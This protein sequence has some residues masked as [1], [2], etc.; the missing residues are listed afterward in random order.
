MNTTKSYIN[1]ITGKGPFFADQE[2]PN[3]NILFISVDMVPREFYENLHGFID[4]KTPNLSA[5]KRDHIFFNNA[6]CSSPLCTP[7]RASYLSGRYSY[8]TVNGERA[9]DGHAV[10]VREEDILFPEYLKSTGYHLRHVGKSHVGAHKFIEMFSENDS[11]WDRWSPPWFDDD[12]YI[13]YLKNMGLERITFDKT[14]YGQD[15]SGQKKGNFYGGWIAPQ[16]GKP[17][18]KEATYPAYLVKKTIQAFE[19]RQNPE[20]PFYFQLDFFGPHQ[21]F[22]IPAGMEEREREIR[23]VLELPESYQHLLNNNFQAF[24]EEP[25]VYR[26]YRKNWGL[27]DPEAMKEYMIA[28]LLQFE[29]LDE[30]IGNVLC[31]LQERDLYDNTWIFLIADH[32]EMNGEMAL[33]D[34]GAYLNPGVIRVPLYLKPSS[35]SEFGD[36]GHIVE[37]P[38]SLLDIAPTIFDITGI[39]TEERLDGISLF[40]TLQNT[41]RPDNKPILCEIW[42]HVIPNPAIGMVFTASDRKKYMFTFNASDDLDEL[43]ELHH[44]KTLKNLIKEENRAVIFEEAIRRMDDIL[45]QDKRWFGYSNFFKLTYAEKLQQPFGDRQLFF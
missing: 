21:P 45:E 30:M 20:Q 6:F 15:P 4:V 11:P 35:S 42:S 27:T 9:H 41:Q 25:R 44:Q 31:Y 23:A 13:T 12:G 22:A 34:K 37:E 8:I 39:S 14:I 29:L 16:N 33:I 5:L 43:Y 17:F 1:S 24:W 32:G 26:M 3:D 10:H 38:V 18:P 36:V 7:S 40:E 28:N 2:K 19:A